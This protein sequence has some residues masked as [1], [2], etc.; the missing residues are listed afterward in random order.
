MF[1]LALNVSGESG[2]AGLAY[3]EGGVAVLPMEFG[4]EDIA[5]VEPAGR[6]FFHVFHQIDDGDFFGH[7]DE[8]VDMIGG[9]VEGHGPAIE[10][11]SDADHIS[12]EIGFYGGG[13]QG[14]AMFGGKDKV[15]QEFGEG[16]CHGKVHRLDE[17]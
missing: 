14:L 9:A 7:G 3:G 16:G 17:I 10:I 12:V 11:A 1:L 8:E 6:I 2:D 4:G 15:D 13:D 5:F